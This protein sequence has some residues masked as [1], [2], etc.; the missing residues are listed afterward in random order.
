MNKTKQAVRI[1]A[2]RLQVR[3][4]TGPNKVIFTGKIIKPAPCIAYVGNISPRVNEKMLMEHFRQCKVL[5]AKVHC[6][7]GV[8][9]TSKP[10]PAGYL[11]NL[12]VLQYGILTF[13]SRVDRRKAMILRCKLDGRKPVVRVAISQLR[14]IKN[15]MTRHTAICQER[16]E[17]ME[18]PNVRTQVVSMLPKTEALRNQGA[19]D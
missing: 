16:M 3:L 4:F 9:T 15:M 5:A 18:R 13:P 8:V 2:T 12:P 11:G 10:P 7:A 1:F 14:E 19:E 17:R 6:C